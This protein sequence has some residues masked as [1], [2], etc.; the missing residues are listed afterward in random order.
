M[1]KVTEVS[2]GHKVGQIYRFNGL[3][4]G[5]QIQYAI[6]GISHKYHHEKFTLS[7]PERVVCMRRIAS[8][9]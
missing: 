7:W 9:W 6:L 3:N 5:E 4:D 1:N 8:V 2:E